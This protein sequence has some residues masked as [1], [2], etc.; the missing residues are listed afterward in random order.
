MK[1]TLILIF[2][3]LSLA[4]VSKAQFS[5][6]YWINGGHNQVLGS[7]I[8]LSMLQKYTHE[9]FSVHAG[10]EFA[11]LHPQNTILNVWGFGTDFEFSIKDF[12]LIAFA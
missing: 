12:Q 4:F 6:Q 7:N 1:K 9:N 3:I 5:G 10:A 8:N 11:L 2:I